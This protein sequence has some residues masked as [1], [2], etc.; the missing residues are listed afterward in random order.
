M[1]IYIKNLKS[2]RIIYIYIHVEIYNAVPYAG[3]FTRRQT[4]A[5]AGR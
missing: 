5:R 2:I 1:Y 3:M 4:M